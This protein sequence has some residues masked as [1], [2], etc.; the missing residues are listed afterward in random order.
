M[1]PPT[2]NWALKFSTLVVVTAC[3]VVLAGTL[4]LSKNF[5]NI[6]TLWGEDVQMNVYLA[7]D[8][9]ESGR[10]FIE[11]KIKEN[12]NVEKIILVTQE[13][14]LNDFRSQM[15]SYA[16]DINQDEELLRL[17]P[18]SFQVKLASSVG[19][20]QQMQSLKELAAVVRPL[21]GV[22]DVSYGQEWIAKYAALISTIEM[23]L[24]IL[25]VIILGAV[26]FVIS[27]A[28]RAS[29]SS[30]KEEIVVMEMIGA[31]Q[32]MIRKPFLI[33]G[34]VLGFFS[35]T[36]GI[37]L[38]FGVYVGIKTLLVEKLNFM[39]LN[40]H[41]QFLS[42][43]AWI[44]FVF[45]ASVLGALASYLCVRRINDGFAGRGQQGSY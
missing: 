21:E 39:Q 29:V 9:S 17:I 13:Q 10:T 3:F 30:R 7:Q 24:S 35:S 20:E 38:C 32:A 43:G 16:P 8:I 36:L 19:A 37:A 27:N 11:N 31:T 28:I 14:A 44:L 4:L 1:R 22:E 6:L 15:A 2:K 23:T 40:Q 18:A 25:G 12:P 26:L 45:G 34:A 5:R 41:I 33:E 42:F